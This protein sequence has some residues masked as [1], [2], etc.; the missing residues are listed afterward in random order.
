MNLLKNWK[1]HVLTLLITLIAEYIGIQKLG[2]MVFLPLLYS[3]V[4]G[5]IISIPKLKLI[6]EEEMVASADYLNVA[7]MILMAKIGLGIG[8][9]L[10]IILNSGWALILQELGHFLGTILFGL[11]V[12]LL[13]GMRRE[14]VGACYSIDREPNI[15]IITDKYGFDSPEGRGVM[16]MYI[17]GTLF[18]AMWISVLSGF[19]SGLDILHPYA[20]AMG[21]GLGSASMMAAGTGS[22]VA[23]YPDHA[24]EV[25]A[26]AGAANLLTTVIGVYFALFISLPVMEK[27]YSLATGRTREEDLEAD[28]KEQVANKEA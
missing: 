19:V 11:P 2:L 1:I 21:S 8:P 5:F 27:A 3:L 6:T 26:L 23:N 7:I 4:L 24:K 22:I 15:A 13:V 9:N 14:A 12:A 16:G 28:A 18:G 20:L 17:C 10:G 25:V